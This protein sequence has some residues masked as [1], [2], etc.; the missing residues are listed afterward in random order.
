MGAFLEQYGIA[1]FVLVIIGIM[2]LMASGVGA[3][4]E[5]LVTQEIKRFTDKSV[6]ENTK[7]VN[8]SNDSDELNEYGFYFNKPYILEYEEDGDMIRFETIFYENGSIYDRETINGEVVY[9]GTSSPIYTFD[10]NKVLHNDNIEFIFKDNGKT[11]TQVQDGEEMEN[12]IL[13]E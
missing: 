4:V 8:G 1:I 9:E 12:Y 11:M 13:A 2:V 7:I 6:E 3:T 10:T 5:G